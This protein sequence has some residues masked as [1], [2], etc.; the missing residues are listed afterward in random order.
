MTYQILTTDKTR[1]PSSLMTLLYGLIVKMYNLQQTFCVRTYKNWQSGVPNGEQ[2]LNPEK[3]I[4]II[5]SRSPLTRKS[6]HVLLKLYGET[7]KIYPQMKFLG[8]TF[9][10][11]LTFQKHFEEILGHCNTGYHP[12]RLIINKKWRPSPSTMLQIYKKCVRQIS[13]MAPFRL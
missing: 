6:E 1:N 11:K 7:L 12:V 2:K 5:N 9:H 8:I 4:V 3:T 10:S 13:N